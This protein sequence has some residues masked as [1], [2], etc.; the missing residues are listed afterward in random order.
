VSAGEF[1]YGDGKQR[2]SLPAYQIMRCPVTVGQ[3]R[4]FCTATKRA[5]APAPPWGL[6]D[7]HPVVNVSWDDAVAFAMWAGMRLPTERE[8]EKAARGTDGRKYPWGSEWDAEKCVNR[9]NSGFATMPVGSKP[10]GATPYGSLDMAGNVWERCDRYS[11][12][13][14]CCVLRGGDYSCGDPGDF[15]VTFRGFLLLS[16]W[17]FCTGFRCVSPPPGP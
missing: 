17:D 10:A 11:D 9:G 7:D 2:V 5:M 12:D 3:Y 13:I 4:A 8:W 14:D 6:I 15:R 1:L 16:D